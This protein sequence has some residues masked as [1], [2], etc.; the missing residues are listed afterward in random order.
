MK[1]KLLLL[2]L[3]LLILATAGCGLLP[4]APAAPGNAGGGLF[5][6][7]P[8]VMT[9]TITNSGDSAGGVVTNHTT[10]VVY[11]VNPAVSDSLEAARLVSTAVP[12]PAGLGLNLALGAAAGILGLIAKSKSNKAS[13]LPA[14]IAGVEAAGQPETKA[15]I[16]KQAS[17]AGVLPRLHAEVRNLTN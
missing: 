16:A 9:S 7:E 10:N 13:L 2:S 5:V 15:A 8:V 14:I 12:H 11:H 1:T 4:S 3:G 17:L 6:G